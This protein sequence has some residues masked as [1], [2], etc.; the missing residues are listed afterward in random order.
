M[1]I[2]ETIAQ[3]LRTQSIH[4]TTVYNALIDLEN[5]GGIGAISDLEYRLSRLVRAM[6][7][8]QDPATDLAVAW[9]GSTRAYLEQYG[10]ATPITAKP[11]R[12]QQFLSTFPARVLSFTQPTPKL[13]AHSS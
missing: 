1:R 10:Q 7:E 3:S 6:K 2:L 13:I 5:G 11:T 8:R 9:L 4:P 12:V